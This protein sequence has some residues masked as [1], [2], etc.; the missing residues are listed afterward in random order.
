MILNQFWK[1][2]L[3]QM[4]VKIRFLNLTRFQINNLEILIL[5]NLKEI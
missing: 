4:T 2:K 5:N 3:K 1:L